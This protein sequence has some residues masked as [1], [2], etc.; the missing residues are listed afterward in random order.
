MGTDS[1]SARIEQTQSLLNYGYRF[2]KTHRLYGARDV[3][4]QPTLWKG[5]SDTLDIGVAEALHVTIP[6]RAYERLNAELSVNNP[7]IAPLEKDA[8]VGQ[9]RVSLEGEVL[10]ERDVIALNSAPEGGVIGRMIDSL[11]LWME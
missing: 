7:L 9:L 4:E 8:A 1:A 10:A 5:E 6:V 2:F 11:R 3:I